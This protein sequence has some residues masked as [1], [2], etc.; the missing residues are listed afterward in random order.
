[1]KSSVLKVLRKSRLPNK[2][3]LFYYITD[4]R[5]LNGMSPAGCVRRALNW[6]VDFIQIREKELSERE[7]YVLTRRI[8]VLTRNTSCRILLNG[9]ADI[10]LAAGADGVHLPSTGL[11]ISD[12][13]S[14]IPSNFMVGVSVHSLRE[15]RQ[16]EAQN[17]DY[18]LVGH[19][20]STK[21]KQ[22]YGRSLGLDF[23]SKA[24]RSTSVPIFGLGGMN[25]ERI[26]PVMQ[27]G[28][29]GVAGISLFQNPK[30][31]SRLKIWKALQHSSPASI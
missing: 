16:A 1:M 19:V 8:V 15:I 25:P 29:V 21:S 18:I 28:A 23:L 26:N 14:W 6:G 9:R 7:L 24:C 2:R 27:A 31:F 30:E 5:Q 13:R 11:Q 20:F 3:P 4:S 12:I 22:G 17:A 10:A